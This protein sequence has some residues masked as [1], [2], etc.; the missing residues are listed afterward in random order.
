MLLSV[1]LVAVSCVLL[2]LLLDNVMLM[3]SVDE[4]AEL[5][6]LAVPELRHAAVAEA[7]RSRFSKLTEPATASSAATAAV[8]TLLDGGAT[9]VCGGTTGPAGFQPSLFVH[10]RLSRELAAALEFPA[11]VLGLAP[12]EPTSAAWQDL[13]RRYRCLHW[14]DTVP[15]RS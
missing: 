11:P 1:L 14:E 4:R 5:M 7:L 10:L 9:L 12:L 2:P 8:R 6:L 3:I 15:D 13:L